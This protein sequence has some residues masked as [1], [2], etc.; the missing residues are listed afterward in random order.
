MSK[1]G[2]KTGLEIAVIGMSGRF[3]GA[4]G[5]ECFWENL[6][7]GIESISFFSDEELSE[8][9][10][11]PGQLKNPNYIKANIMLED[12]EYFDSVFFDYTPIEA[13][14]MDPQI[15]IFHECAWLALEDAGYCPGSYQGLIGLYAG[16]SSSFLWEAAS[17][18]SGEREQ[19]GPFAAAHVM[20]KDILTLRVSY[21]LNLTGPVIG[22]NTSCST[23]LVTIHL[24][25]QGL[26]NGEC[27]IALAGGISV[28]QLRKEGYPYQ[29]G[30]IMSADGHCRA[31]A[32]EA[33]GTIGGEGVGIV[34]LKRLEEAVADG[35]T[36]HAVIKGS[37]IN[38]DGIRK[39]GFTAPSVEGQAEVIKTALHLAAVEPETIGYIE[40]HGT[41][42]V[43]GDP[44]EIEGLK[45][46][47]NTKKKKFCRIGSV[48]TNV[49]HL[50]AA[51]GVTGF[52]KTVLM[53]KNQLIPPSLHFFTPNPKIDF[54]NSPFI[55]NQGL[56]RW[57]RDKYPLRAGV[58][59]FG[60]GGTNA[61]VVLEEF[62]EETRGLAPLPDVHPS[63]N[64]QL[65]L[66]SAKTETAL[67]K[68]T[69]NL[70]EYFKK[71]LLNRANHENP[72]H[73]GPTLADAAYTLQVGRKKFAYRRMLVC[74]DLDEAIELLSGSQE[75]IYSYYSST[76]DQVKP[77]IFMFPGQGAQYVNMGL[78]LYKTEPVFRKEMDRCFEIL[79]TL[80][81]YDI[82]QTLYPHSPVNSPLERGAPE[83]RGVSNK[84]NQTEIAQP[85]IFILEYA[86]ARLLMHWG[87][88]P[89]AMIG[90]SIG[91]YTAA[92][93]AGVFTLE[94]TLKLVVIRGKLMQQM[95]GGAMLSVPLPEEK[96]T[97]LLMEKKDIELAAVNAPSLCV[98]TGNYQA[99]ND[100]EKELNRQ[101]YQCTPLHTSHAFHSYLMEPIL[102]KFAGEVGEITGSEPK[103]PYISNVTGQWITAEQV[104]D[105]HYW[106]KHTRNT[107]RFSDGVK[108]ILKKKH[109]LFVEIGP[110][111]ALSTL[112]KKHTNKNQ[113]EDQGIINLVRHPR[114]KVKDD[115]YLLSKIGQLWLT[116]INPEWSKYYGEEKRYRIPLPTYSFDWYR[117][118][119]PSNPFKM[120]KNM[121][122]NKNLLSKKKNIADWFYFPS[123]K[124]ERLSI[125]KPGQVPAASKILFFIDSGDFGS[126]LAKGLEQKGHQVTLVKAGTGFGKENHQVY[127][128]DPGESNDYN[129]LFKELKKLQLLP[130]IIVHS[131]NVTRNRH[132][133]L[134]VNRSEKVTELTFYS[135]IYIARAIGEQA[136]TEQIQI[137]VITDHMQP[138]TGEEELCP[139]KS[140]V[141]GP[142]HVIPQEYSNISCYSLDIVLPG[143]GTGSC[144][145]LL[146]RLV[147]EIVTESPDNIV[148]IIAYRGINRWVQRFEPIP[149]EKSREIEFATR[150]R[151]KGVYLIT[152][153]LG[154]IGLV[155]GKYLAKTVQAKLILTSRSGLPGR[156]SWDEWLETHEKK[157]PISQ[158][159]REIQ[160]LENLGAEVI[161]FS[162]DASDLEKMQEVVI[163]AKN[164]FSQINGV[165]HSAGVP[166]GAMIQRRTRE[167]S[168]AVFQAKIK[169][170]LVLD[171]IFR[172]TELDFVVFCSSMASLI[173]PVGQAAY[174]AANNFL[175]AFAYYKTS[176]DHL[177]TVSI[178]WDTWQE[179]G[180]A[181]EALKDFLENQGNPEFR[182]AL[183]HGIDNCEGA[184]AFSR[185]LEVIVPQVVVS[186]LD[187]DTRIKHFYNPQ[188]DDSM[189]FSGTGLTKT[190]HRRPQLKVTYAA[191]KDDMEKT[192]ANTWKEVLGLDKV[193]VNDNFFEI[194]GDSLKII[195]LNNKIKIALKKEIPIQLMFS[196]STVR[197]LSRYLMQKENPTGSINNQTETS[198]EPDQARNIMTQTVNIIKGDKK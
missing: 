138:V 44:V 69:E 74:S 4:K 136:I 70:A 52:I 154:G 75:H 174:C 139:E 130:D 181:V 186:T 173:S 15:R 137:K 56:T 166:D 169:G 65:I 94:E 82:K 83:G 168:E 191:P 68:M 143:T 76:D 71:N 72:P 121:T 3:P 20:D 189:A 188:N 87:I 128:I 84:I 113:T 60:I 57:K 190:L 98:V 197:S 116:G 163:Q 177:F 126:A 145:Q 192:M 19:V 39:L 25:C 179:S 31:F 157:D 5:I 66:L 13:R 97:P 102:K 92:C 160:E 99:V 62:F 167:H 123:W 89:D 10:V 33:N 42:T 58:S 183:K 108:E 127:H 17:Y 110:G 112:V 96:L 149:L 196:Y 101:G 194:G 7:N 162:A 144:E 61:H 109:P 115:C 2:N 118:S 30:M 21:K 14:L 185:I 147:M 88:N 38:N 180:M 172:N 78:D 18:L 90:H 48:K 198:R 122:D 6:K 41:G 119:P 111:R 103:I 53:L 59:S 24:A 155:L 51:A 1:N 40:T 63:R 91:E 54:E 85:V 140:T 117:Y 32:A 159:I 148:N 9:G 67:D 16:A 141:L 129:E 142:V 153:G 37:A 170:T 195:E 184:E 12:I 26:L 165:V 193:G 29:E 79:N 27:D 114:E 23:S 132:H 28:G 50:D 35:D 106:V 8:A 80:V 105:S 124:Q 64:Y 100:F 131:W 125:L 45:L 107:V 73:P 182:D 49:G 135:L 176:R 95:P 120:A 161:L 81:D 134:D 46:A 187:L 77:V 150:L 36:I 151:E 178:N 158:K 146:D 175:D 171:T 133:Q 152:G 22:M 164:R 43:L 11:E 104:K 34:V 93:L 156:A 86:L 55:V 47:F